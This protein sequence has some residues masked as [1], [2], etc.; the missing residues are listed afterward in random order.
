MLQASPLQWMLPFTNTRLSAWEAL[1]RGPSPWASFSHLVTETQCVSW[2]DDCP[3][4]LAQGGYREV[5]TFLF[6]GRGSPL[7]TKAIEDNKARERDTLQEESL[8][9]HLVFVTFCVFSKIQL[10]EVTPFLM[11]LWV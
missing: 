10:G 5:F 2:P 11:V 7:T 8:E 9:C 1:I 6:W 4:L 3:F